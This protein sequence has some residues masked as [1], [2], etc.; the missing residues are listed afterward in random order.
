MLVAVGIFESVEVG[1]LP[2]GHTHEDV[3]QAFS[4]TLAR[5]RVNN[6]IT[7][8]DLHSELRQTN[9]AYEVDVQHMQRV[10]NWSALCDGENCLRKIDKVTQWRYF[11]FTRDPLAPMMSDLNRCRRSALSR[12]TA[13]THGRIFSFRRPAVILKVHFVSVRTSERLLH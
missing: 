4:Q 2:V 1:F 13:P 12:R 11:F 10:A 3:D 8:N 9:R 5:L 7:L 6:A